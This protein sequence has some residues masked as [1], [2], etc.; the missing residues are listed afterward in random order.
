MIFKNNPRR[1][2]GE[3]MLVDFWAILMFV[4]VLVVFFIVFII[5]KEG[6][7]RTN[8]IQEKFISSDLDYMLDA[9]IKSP[10]IKDST[11]T[12]GEIIVEDYLNGDY[13]RT[14]ESFIRFFSGTNKTNNN[15]IGGYLFVI[16]EGNNRVYGK[17]MNFE[18]ENFEKIA[19][20]ANL[21]N[22]ITLPSGNVGTTVQVMQ[23]NNPLP[24]KKTGAKIIIPTN[25]GKELEVI[26]I[27]AYAQEKILIFE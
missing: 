24:V 5:T 8:T 9:Y 17:L 10:Y 6:S 22:S 7:E 26:I 4:I 14:D 11:K 18:N 23:G 12:N 19:G 1:K 15:P 27:M 25:D 3:D 2:K 13:S 20:D 16:K 21:M